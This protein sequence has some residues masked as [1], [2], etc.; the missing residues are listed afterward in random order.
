MNLEATI[1]ATPTAISVAE[2]NRHHREFG[3]ITEQ[4]RQAREYT[5]AMFASVLASGSVTDSA[6]SPPKRSPFKER[7]FQGVLGGQ[8]LGIDSQEKLLRVIEECKKDPYLAALLETSGNP[9]RL[10]AT[11]HEAN[12]AMESPEFQA[13]LSALP[14]AVRTKIVCKSRAKDVVANLIAK[15]IAEGG[16][17]DLTVKNNQIGDW[18]REIEELFNAEIALD[19]KNR[20]TV[21]MKKYKRLYAEL[22]KKRKEN[23][24]NEISLKARKKV[25]GFEDPLDSIVMP[26]TEEKTRGVFDGIRSIGSFFRNTVGSWFGGSKT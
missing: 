16:S 19:P 17:L 7:L 5:T 9:L 6:N 4:F 25:A 8:S 11:T 3:L 13:A 21:K 23:R 20:D 2:E 1:D 24:K 10:T 22:R 18:M 14:D 15:P 26:K 12:E